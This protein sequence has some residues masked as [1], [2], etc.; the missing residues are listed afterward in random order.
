MSN[1]NKSLIFAF[2]LFVIWALI[3]SKSVILLVALNIFLLVAVIVFK[4]DEF[5]C[6]KSIAFL[7]ETKDALVCK[8]VGDEICFY[9][10][11]KLLNK[12]KFR[13]AINNDIILVTN[14]GDIPITSGNL[15]IKPDNDF[16]EYS[17][18][19]TIG[20]FF[21]KTSTFIPIFN[22]DVTRN[23]LPRHTESL[24]FFQNMLYEKVANSF[25]DTLNFIRISKN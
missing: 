2:S 17:N 14:N 24:R 1:L 7:Y 3:F 6:N 16:V 23:L 19:M 5:I 13:K 8:A 11:N 10:E 9:A 18:K 12:I 4:L 22:A 25:V 21:D 20:I 15:I